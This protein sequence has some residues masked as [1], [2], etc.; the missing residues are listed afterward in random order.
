MT[1]NICLI[2]PRRSTNSLLI[3]L[4]LQF[5]GNLRVQI[6]IHIWDERSKDDQKHTE[7]DSRVE[8]ELEGINVG[9][10][11]GCAN[12]TFDIGGDGGGRAEVYR[13]EGGEERAERRVLQDSVSCRIAV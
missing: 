3:T 9:V 12:G 2:C 13:A 11:D 6:C 8:N 1:H 10:C 5:P 7:W 4:P